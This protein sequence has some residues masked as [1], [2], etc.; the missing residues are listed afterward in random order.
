MSNRVIIYI[1]SG[2]I[3]L[4]AAID[5]LFIIPQTKFGVVF[6]FGEAVSIDESPGLKAKI[7]FIQNVRVFDKRLLP[8]DIEPKEIFASD[9]KRVIVDAFARYRITDPI[10]F[11]KT[12]NNLESVKVRLSSIIDSSLRKIIGEVPLLTLLSEKRE[13]IMQRINQSA[14]D[15]I[16]RFGIEIVD[17]RILR[18]DLPKSN[19]REV[20]ARMR[21][22]REKTANRIRDEGSQEATRIKAEGERKKSVIIADA[23]KSAQIYRGKADAQAAKIYNRSFDKDR[24]FYNFYRSMDVYKNSLD[25]DTTQYLLNP[26]NE[27]FK[28]LKLSPN[29]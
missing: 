25:S 2:I 15:K 17:V 22:D 26:D 29:Q 27:I 21:S 11:Y 23:K 28:Y 20:Y 8:L 10:A 6:Q 16:Q 1:L 4:F 7:P 13:N 5:S 14:N 24:E 18:A 9:S 19:S 3:S 12:V